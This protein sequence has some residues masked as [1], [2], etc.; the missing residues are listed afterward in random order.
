MPDILIASASFLPHADP[1]PLPA[2]VWL[3][4][5]LHQLTLSLHFISVYLLLG[6]LL[7]AVLLNF[8]GHRRGSAR[9]IN[10][11]G[12]ISNWLP[13]IMT[14]VI[15]LGV[16]PLLFAQV[17]Y[18]QALYASS[19]LIGASWIAVIPLLIVCYQLLYLMKYRASDGKPFALLG[20]G[21]LLTAW[22]IAR[23]YT[24][25]MTLMLEPSIWQQAYATTQT[26]TLALSGPASWMRW[27]YM[28]SGGVSWVGLLLIWLARKST[29]ETEDKAFMRQLGTR[30]AQIGSVLMVAAGFA[31]WDAQP[32][33]VQDACS[34]NHLGW[35]IGVSVWAIGTVGFVTAITY[36]YE[37][38]E[39]SNWRIPLLASVCGLLQ[40][41]GFV[42]CRDLIR[43]A[44]LGRFGF[45]VW[46]RIVVTNW[47]VV[48]LFL[49][50][51]VAGLG[52]LGW[53]ISVGYRAK[54]EVNHE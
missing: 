8:L 50:L 11:S 43:D 18:G 39:A 48:G 40:T 7:T 15:N 21:S 46:D 5:F 6:G 53:L 23:I 33:V 37:L 49:L 24:M 12:A 34:F 27:G 51:F 29:I 17:L 31:V 41:V 32:E 47:S 9:A 44:S 26:G 54:N 10:A 36:M 25:N 45:D 13:I 52:V 3:F 22:A 1:I 4:R 16:P 2:P 14:Y 20:L 42:F 28:L 30:L 38:T 35:R 19:I